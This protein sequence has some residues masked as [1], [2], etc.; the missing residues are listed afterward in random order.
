MAD[1]W[2]FDRAGAL[3]LECCRSVGLGARSDIAIVGLTERSASS[4]LSGP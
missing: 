4:R 2:S 3:N 1:R